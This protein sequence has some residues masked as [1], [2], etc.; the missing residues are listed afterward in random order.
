[1]RT[2]VKGVPT[3]GVY[4]RVRGRSSYWYFRYRF[5]KMRCLII[6]DIRNCFRLTNCRQVNFRKNIRCD[7]RVIKMVENK[8]L[9][10]AMRMLR[11][12]SFFEGV[13]VY[14]RRVVDHM[15]MGEKRD[16]AYIACKQDNEKPLWKPFFRSVHSTRRYI[17]FTSHRAL[18]LKLS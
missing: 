17:F 2:T 12:L 5:K 11:F 3:N 7:R 15:G 10:L 1:M 8:K 6:I 16:P 4:L 9:I 13:R 18:H 14:I